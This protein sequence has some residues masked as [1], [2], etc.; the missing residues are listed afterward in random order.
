M[1]QPLS[2]HALTEVIQG[3]G[4]TFTPSSVLGGKYSRDVI[5]SPFP[6]FS[7]IK[8]MILGSDEVI[9]CV[10]VSLHIKFTDGWLQALMIVVDRKLSLLGVNANA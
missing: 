1:P 9:L 7:L 5:A 8:S 3:N 10:S 2:V 4:R 6:H